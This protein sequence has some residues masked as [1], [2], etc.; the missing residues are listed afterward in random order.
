MA[1]TREGGL[2]TKLS[3]LERYGEDFYKNAGRK[4]GKKKGVKKGFA[5]NP[6]LAAIA[7]AKGGRNRYG[8]RKYQSFDPYFDNNSNNVSSS[9][10]NEQE[11]KGEK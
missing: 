3:V 6:K 7:G 4:G 5:A 9:R 11:M 8:W 10:G 1:G 2:K